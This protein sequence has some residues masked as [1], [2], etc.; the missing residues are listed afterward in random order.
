M[1]LKRFMVIY[2]LSVFGIIPLAQAAGPLETLKGPVEE[3]IRL[4][5][6]PLY[7]DAALKQ[8]QR[9]KIWETIQTVFNFNE[10]GKRTLSRNWK[11]FSPKE[12]KSFVDVFSEFLGNI[13]VDKIQGEYHNEK[14]AFLDE[15]IVKN[16]RALVR[17]KILRESLEIPVDYKMKL[18]D[19]GWKIY[20]VNIEG[21]SLVKNYRVQFKKILLKNSHQYLIERIQKKLKT[22]KENY[23]KGSK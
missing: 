12:R 23:A 18:F 7:R 21:V 3:V 2:C 14:I 10:V 16:T 15:K 19:E 6:D 1:F 22:Q 17:T 9:D 11:R 8:Q 5:N 4:L 13:Y 20:D